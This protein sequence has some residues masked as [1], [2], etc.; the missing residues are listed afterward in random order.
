[1]VTVSILIRRVWIPGHVLNLNGG[2]LET[3]RL[4]ADFP[5]N[6]KLSEAVSDA[7][8][9]PNF[10]GPRAKVQVGKFPLNPDMCSQK[11]VVSA[12]VFFWAPDRVFLRRY[13][14]FQQFTA[15]ERVSCHKP[16]FLRCVFFFYVGAE[17]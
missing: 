13:R 3:A 1:M 2:V 6:K 8:R 17:I 12:C 15:V 4:W 5:F 14:D 11:E 7:T 9:S 16:F 10:P